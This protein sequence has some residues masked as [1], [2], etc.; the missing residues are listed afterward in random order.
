MGGLDLKWAQD[1]A[2]P[3][4]LGVTTLVGGA[5]ARAWCWQGLLLGPTEG[6]SIPWQQYRGSYFKI[7]GA[8]ATTH[9]PTVL[10]HLKPLWILRPQGLWFLKWCPC[11]SWYWFRLLHPV[12]DL[13]D[14]FRQKIP[15]FLSLGHFSFYY[16]FDYFFPSSWFFPLPPSTHTFVITVQDGCFNFHLPFQ[17]QKGE[18]AC[19]P[20]K[21]TAWKSHT[22]IPLISY[23][24]KLRPMIIHSCKRGWEM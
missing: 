3:G 24:Q 23:C 21:D 13:E 18:E 10:S 12:Q 9:N 20:F 11:V 14:M 15:P 17:P 2:S 16:F 7:Q 22:L 1:K 19:P 5:V 8:E 6:C 4:M